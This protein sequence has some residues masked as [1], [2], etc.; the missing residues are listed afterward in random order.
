[1][2]KR[3]AKINFYKAGTGKSARIILSIPLLKKIGITEKEREVEIIYDKNI[4]EIKKIL[5]KY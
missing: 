2:E 5:K 3:Y 4:I 1:M